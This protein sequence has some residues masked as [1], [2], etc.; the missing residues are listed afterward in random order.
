MFKKASPVNLVSDKV[1]L[2]H[3]LIFR[4]VEN[5]HSALVL[6]IGRI[7]KIIKIPLTNG[8]ITFCKYFRNARV[9]Y[10]NVFTITFL[11]P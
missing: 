7:I 10:L 11:F 5:V 3:V 8:K 1:D 4:Y 6:L 9:I 2:S